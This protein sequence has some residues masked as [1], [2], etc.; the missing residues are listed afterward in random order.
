MDS[1]LAGRYAVP[2]ADGDVPGLVA[3][4]TRDVAA[5]GATLTHRRFQPLDERHPVALRYA[6]A[7][8][9]LDALSDGDAAIPG[10]AVSAAGA[11]AVENPYDGT[12]FLPED[13]D[14]G[15]APDRAVRWLG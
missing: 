7:T 2:F 5:Y 14:L 4:L 13:F 9:L 3:L 8:A 1:K 10:E 6:K 15:P 11:V 12:L